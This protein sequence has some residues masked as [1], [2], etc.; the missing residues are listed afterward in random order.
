MRMSMHPS[1]EILLPSE[2]TATF[3]HKCSNMNA[4]S[5]DVANDFLFAGFSLFLTDVSPTGLSMTVDHG[6]DETA[7]N[8]NNPGFESVSMCFLLVFH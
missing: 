4:T 6:A 2:S 5:Y 3:A 1:G 8:S 7:D